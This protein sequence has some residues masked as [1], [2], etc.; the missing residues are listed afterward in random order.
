MWRFACNARLARQYF[1]MNQQTFCFWKRRAGHW[2][3]KILVMPAGL[4]LCASRYNFQDS[5][6]TSVPVFVAFNEILRY[7]HGS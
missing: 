1:R 5:G 3:L 4:R 2:N 6:G 7:T